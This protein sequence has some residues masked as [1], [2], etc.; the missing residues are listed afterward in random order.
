MASSEA[1]CVE[2]NLGPHGFAPPEHIKMPT[3]KWAPANESDPFRRGD[4]ATQNTNSN[5]D[6]DH[7]SCSLN[8]QETAYTNTVPGTF[9][10]CPEEGNA[11]CP[12]TGYCANGDDCTGCCGLLVDGRLRRRSI[13][14][15]TQSGYMYEVHIFEGDLGGRRYRVAAESIWDPRLKRSVARQVTLGSV[16]PTDDADL[17]V[18]F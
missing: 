7:E 4:F 11:A 18:T 1:G 12:A 5:R 15:A 16:E 17:G 3:L 9:G 2:K 8:Y 6:A 13:A 14:S 10:T